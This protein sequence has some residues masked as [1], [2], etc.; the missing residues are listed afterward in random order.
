MAT[1]KFMLIRRLLRN[2]F[3]LCANMS[4]SFILSGVGDL[5]EQQYELMVHELDEWDRTRTKNMAVCGCSSGIICHY[6]YDYLDAMIPGKSFIAVSKKVFAD[7]VFCSPVTIG[8]FI[9]TQGILERNSMDE[10][11][12]KM[13]R[14]FRDLY[15][16]EWIV[17]PT[18]Q[19]INFYVL[20]LKYRVLYDNVISLLFDVYMSNVVNKPII[21]L[22]LLEGKTK[23]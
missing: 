2:K 1:Q 20:P 19:Y 16:A 6:W 5:L 14:N 8:L 17:W 15:I 10:F 23:K 3:L 11:K 18:A 7:L 4:V 12:V 9:L 13:E 22:E 21:Q